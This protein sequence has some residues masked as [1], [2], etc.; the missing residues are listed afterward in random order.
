MG[1]VNEEVKAEWKEETTTFQRVKSVISREYEGKTAAEIAEDALV[2]ETTARGHLEDLVDD[3]FVEKTT[4]GENG[5][6]LYMR[7]W[8]S[9]VFEQAQ[10][11]VEHADSDELLE[12][13]GEMENEIEDY[14]TETGLDSPED[15]AWSDADVDEGTLLQWRTTR[16]NLS[17]VKVAIALDKAGDVVRPQAKV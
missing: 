17:F 16:R 8:E 12:K 10:D 15:I 3:G 7:S 14:R 1:N 4:D 11:I 9:Y 2:S 6:S 5:A 13:V